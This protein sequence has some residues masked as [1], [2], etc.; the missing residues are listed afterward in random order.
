MD[1]LM[2]VIP[3]IKIYNAT[4]NASI[5]ES[6]IINLLL[7]ALLMGCKGCEEE[8]KPK[9]E[10][11]KLPPP[12]LEGKDTF[13]CLVNGKAWYTTSSTN[14]V[15][16]YQLGGLSISA[17]ILIP[18]FQSIGI[19]LRDPAGG[20][21][22]SEGSYSLVYP[23]EYNPWASFNASTSCYYGGTSQSRGDANAG[24][25]VITRFD[26]INY[27]VSGTFEFNIT[28]DGCETM[29]I[30]HGRFDIRYAP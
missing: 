21:S 23:N 2:F 17:E 15:A 4:K 28:H 3:L 29:K 22:L 12:T 13:G 9:T 8:P 16:S 10:L 25:L 24:A 26:K 27:I 20:P 30:T 19:S 14:A 1:A 6:I 11:E 5:I 7:A 18:L